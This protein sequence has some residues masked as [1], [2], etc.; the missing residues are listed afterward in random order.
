MITCA[1]IIRNEIARIR[2]TLRHVLSLDFSE[3]LVVDQS[4]DDGTLEAVH[5]F[6][7]RYP[8]M[9]VESHPCYGC[10]EM[11]RPWVIANAK[12]PFV[13]LLDADEEVTTWFASRMN[14]IAASN[15]ADL[16]YLDRITY[17]RGDKFVLDEG[18]HRF[19]QKDR[20]YAEVFENAVD[21][22]HSPLSARDGNRVKRIDWPCLLTIKS[23]EEQIA[24]NERYYGLGYKHPV[25]EPPATIGESVAEE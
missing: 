12:G 15:A 21:S 14:A 8:R 16:Y 5:A 7:S 22:L 3:V 18:M 4:S 24:D 10:N 11:S 23:A 19:F 17:I 13:L 2:T 25:I 20:A 1:L 9:R 6:A